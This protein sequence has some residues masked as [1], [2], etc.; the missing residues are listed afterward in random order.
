MAEYGPEGLA[1]LKARQQQLREQEIQRDPHRFE[2]PEDDPS[3]HGL[4]D[5]EAVFAAEDDS[6]TARPL[7]QLFR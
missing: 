1:K 5:H 6:D 7:D 2:C 3:E 4:F